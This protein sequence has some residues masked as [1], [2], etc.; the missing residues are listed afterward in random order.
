VSSHA[1]AG[2]TGEVPPPPGEDWALGQF[3]K[4]HLLTA[5][6]QHVRRA[7]GSLGSDLPLHDLVY[8]GTD[9]AYASVWFGGSE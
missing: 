1:C 3:D 9:P 8:P 7:G 6:A 4:V 2:V 5:L